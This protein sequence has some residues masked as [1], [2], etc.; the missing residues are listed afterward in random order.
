MVVKEAGNPEPILVGNL[1][2]VVVLQELIVARGVLEDDVVELVDPVVD[3][4]GCVFVL[5]VVG[6]EGIGDRNGVGDAAAEVVVG[7]AG[8]EE[9]DREEEEECGGGGAGVG[10]VAGTAAGSQAEVSEEESV[11]HFFAAG[12][13]GDASG[14]GFAMEVWETHLGED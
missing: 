6:D 11:R 12:D 4:D 5:G 9:R 10:A 1:L 7:E 3:G 14:I 8:V 13:D 2:V